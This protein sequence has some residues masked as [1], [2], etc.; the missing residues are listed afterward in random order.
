MTTNSEYTIERVFIAGTGVMGQ[1]IAQVFAVAGYPVELFDIEP[2][3]VDRAIENLTKSISEEVKKGRLSDDLADAAIRNIAASASAGPIGQSTLVIE[4]IHEDINAK[5]SLF[6]ELEKRVHDKTIL[7]TNTSS[8]SVTSI[9][10]SCQHPSRV[11]GFHFF[12]PVPRMRLVEIVQA[13]ETN[14]SVVDLLRMVS[15]KIGFKAI[16]TADTPGFVVNHAGRAYVTEALQLTGEHVADFET[17]DG[18]LRDTAGFRMGPFELLDLTGL[19]VSHPVM[20]SIYRQYYE[21][22][23]YRPSSITRVRLEGKLLGR[24]SGRGFYAY[25]RNTISADVNTQTSMDP[26]KPLKVFFGD[27]GSAVPEPLRQ[28]LTRTGL[29]RAT[30]AI[31]A[32]VCIVAPIG[33]DIASTVQRSGLKAANTIAV[34]GLFFSDSAL[35][36][37][38]SA[39]TSQETVDAASALARSVNLKPYWISDSAGYV[40]QRVVGMI[41]HLACEMAQQH[42]AAPKDIDLAVKTA[43][44]YPKGPFEWGQLLG[45]SRL[46]QLMQEIFNLT[47]DPRYRPSQWLRRRV[48]LNIPLETMS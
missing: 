9:A 36:F 14:A 28:L 3:A 19:D 10:A 39:G 26:E 47:G 31:S 45:P 20:E 33:S 43:L 46:L 22:P 6:L 18:I 21:D 42:I 35:T 48:Q 25:P 24:K 41:V 5:R 27:G 23:R 1:G 34:D 17:I 4:A 8:L 32:D 13:L 12:N 29:A 37:M 2:A 38:R 11:I 16:V 7:A 30:D 44:G 15:Q 40:A